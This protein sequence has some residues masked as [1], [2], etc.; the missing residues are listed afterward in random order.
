MMCSRKKG[1]V[2]RMKMLWRD[3]KISADKQTSKQ[4]KRQV[5]KQRGQQ[6]FDHGVLI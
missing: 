4:I 2:F 6:Q 5:I 1:L 3:L